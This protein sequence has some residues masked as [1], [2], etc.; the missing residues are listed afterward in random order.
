MG[1][2]V[3]AWNVGQAVGNS[4]QADSVNEHAVAVAGQADG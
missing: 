3:S 1:A 4:R 2:Q